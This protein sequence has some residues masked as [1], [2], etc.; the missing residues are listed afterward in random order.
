[1]A[2]AVY[3]FDERLAMSQGAD[4]GSVSAIL[5][6]NIPGANSV[7]KASVSNDKSG[8]DYWVEHCSGKHLSID[9]KVREEDYSAKPN[10]QDDLALETWSVMEHNK[11]GWTR[12][13]NKRSDYILWYWLDTGRWCLISFPYLCKVFQDNWTL[14]VKAYKTREQVTPN[15]GRPYRSQCVFVP[16]REVWAEIYRSFAG[17]PQE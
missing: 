6:A 5:L 3:D 9:V 7:S 13:S 17:Q 1:M 4:K 10:K 14:W 15:N 2:N 11:V 16:R 8:T 12:D